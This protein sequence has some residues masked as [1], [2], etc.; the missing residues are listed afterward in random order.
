MR[1]EDFLIEIGTEEL[2][3][4]LLKA[5]I[6]GFA[7]NI[8]HE[9]TVSGFGFKS[10]ESYGTPRRLAIIVRSLEERQ[11]DKE[12]EKRGPAVS[13]A[14]N[15]D[16]TPTP[17]L[18][19]FMRACGITDPNLLE[20]LKNKKGEWLFYR[21]HEQGRTIEE[22]VQG[23]IDRSLAQ[24]NVERPMRWSSMREEFVRPVHWVVAL[25][26]HEVLE[27]EIFGCKASNFSHGH[28]FM[29]PEPVI[30]LT[31]KEY[32]EKC[33]DAKVVVDPNEREDLIREKVNMEGLKLGGNIELE[34]RL[35]EEVSALVEWPEVLSG[36]FDE[37]FLEIPE[38]VLI[39]V[40]KKHQ[41]YFHLRGREDGRLLAKFITVTNIVSKKP[42]VVIQGNER[43]IKPRLRDAQFFFA[44]DTKTK[45]E[46][47]LSLL[48]K[49]TFQKELGS[50]REKADR[51]SKLAGYIARQLGWN[52]KNAERA[53]LLSKADLVTNM[54]E[55]FPELQGKMGSHYAR[56]DGE[57]PEVCS[58]INNH[59]KPSG[60][61]DVVPENGIGSAVALADKLDTLVSIFGVGGEPTGSK[62]PYA[63]RRQTLGVIRIVL[64]HKL[65]INV[66]KCLAKAREGLQESG[67]LSEEYHFDITK[68]YDYMLERLTHYYQEIGIESDIVRAVRGRE[69]GIINLS[70]ADETIRAI[71]EFRTHNKGSELIALSK[72]V[73]NIISD[74]VADEL[75]EVRA[76]LY[77][78]KAEE[79]LEKGMEDAE[80]KLRK[81]KNTK[82][83]LEVLE[84]QE[85]VIA[86]Y[87]GNVL[88]MDEDE[89]KRL[90]RLA[91][92]AR[93]N[94]LFKKVADFK[95]LRVL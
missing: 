4:S 7:D 67:R 25:F 75:P 74:Q 77:E 52:Q 21:Q 27:V 28:R 26:G 91:A 61:Q 93:M 53:G 72:R 63:L 95:V 44:N 65:D 42:E 68:V 81:A 19:G 86:D 23:I 46:E 54:V 35:V 1:T 55:E 20:R 88:V 48:S 5:L 10:L 16:G 2:P 73:A 50:Y 34:N 41:R 84:A 17:A 56:I 92:V 24:L 64:V 11:A 71:Q 8:R 85:A 32:V 80:R 15:Q 82:E 38:E 76:E 30:I 33:R 37:E 58:A 66:E 36:A 45:L 60:P 13:R 14:Y 51:V 29:H 94:K 49:V 22:E 83:K 78:H 62:D 43:V 31:A 89:S 12:S 69:G 6:V 87:F 90:N 9:L 79:A 47:K 18:H 40:M 57:L 3:P 59:Y 70:K 39:S